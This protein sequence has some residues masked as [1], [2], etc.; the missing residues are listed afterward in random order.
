MPLYEAE[1]YHLW[2]N[3][4]D[5]NLLREY[6]REMTNKISRCNICGEFLSSKRELKRHIDKNHRITAPKITAGIMK[7]AVSSSSKKKTTMQSENDEVE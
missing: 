2:L 1:C 6:K 4:G 7:L 3:S 5:N